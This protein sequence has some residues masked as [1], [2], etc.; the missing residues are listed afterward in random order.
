MSDGDPLISHADRFSGL[1]FWLDEF[2]GKSAPAHPTLR[3]W[4]LAAVHTLPPARGRRASAG[5]RRTR[6]SGGGGK[7][8]QPAASVVSG[9]TGGADEDA[10][11]DS[12]RIIVDVSGLNVMGERISVRVVEAEAPHVLLLENGSKARAGG[13]SRI[14]F[15]CSFRICFL[16]PAPCTWDAW[17]DVPRSSLPP[18]STAGAA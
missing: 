17:V 7:G 1:P 4:F 14:A 11:A 16:S 2:T 12:R 8:K 10:S 15:R 5:G 6:S 3:S 18:C 13:R 9:D